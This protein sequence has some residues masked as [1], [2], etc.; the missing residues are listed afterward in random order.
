MPDYYVENRIVLDAKYKPFGDNPQGNK[1]PHADD[2]QQVSSYMHILDCDIGGFVFPD[3]IGD[4]SM[5]E[6]GKLQSTHLILWEN[7]FLTRHRAHCNTVRRH[8]V[9]ILIVRVGLFTVFSCVSH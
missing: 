5:F 1:Y 3:S 4:Y 6:L 8:M 9:K 2:L 7:C